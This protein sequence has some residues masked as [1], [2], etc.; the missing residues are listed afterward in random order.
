[1]CVCG[2][3]NT[4]IKT[5]CQ[6]HLSAQNFFNCRQSAGLLVTMNECYSYNPH[7]P[8]RQTN[9]GMPCGYEFLHN[10]P[11]CL[12]NWEEK[13]VMVSGWRQVVNLMCFQSFIAKC[14]TLKKNQSSFTFNIHRNSWRM[15]A[16]LGS[17]CERWMCVFITGAG[18]GLMRQL[19]K[20]LKHARSSIITDQSQEKNSGVLITSSQAAG[21]GFEFKWLFHV[22]VI[23]L[24]WDKIVL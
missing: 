24:H 10:Q 5:Q 13:V 4:D 7:L 8:H 19:S 2:T 12:L 22:H 18:A 23:E 9:W 3:C 20:R 15:D 21:K 14:D 17:F 11:A 16:Y 1:M 6:V